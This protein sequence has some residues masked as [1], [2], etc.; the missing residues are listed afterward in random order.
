MKGIY[1]NIRNKLLEKYDTQNIKV[2]FGNGMIN[3]IFILDKKKIR[4]NKKW[5][6]EH[7]HI[8]ELLINYVMVMREKYGNCDYERFDLNRV[9]L[10]LM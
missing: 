6:S 7:K 1:K 9:M 3:S 10:E 5:V 8:N 2:E 4:L